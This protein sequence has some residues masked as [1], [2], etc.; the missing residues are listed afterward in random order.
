MWVNALW[1]VSRVAWNWL[2]LK[3]VIKFRIRQFSSQFIYLL[4]LQI[5]THQ[6]ICRVY[7]FGGIFDWIFFILFPFHKISIECK[8]YDMTSNF[9]SLRI[10]M[11]LICSGKRV[12]LIGNRI[13]T[14]RIQRIPIENLCYWAS[15][16]N[17]NS[18]FLVSCRKSQAHKNL[19]ISA[20]S[21]LE[22]T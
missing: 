5:A 15:R 8:I 18:M 14:R 16:V 2:W 4:S 22:L 6:F 12:P 3:S 20:M 13:C 7:E 1:L 9:E 19:C 10:N 21:E 11:K 17:H